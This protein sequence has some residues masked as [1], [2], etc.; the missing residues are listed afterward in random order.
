MQIYKKKGN[1]I[2]V[3]TKY[4]YPHLFDMSWFLQLLF[5]ISF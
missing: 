1:N 3:G 5:V 2:A 4:Y